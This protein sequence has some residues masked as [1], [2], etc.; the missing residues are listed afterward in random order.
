MRRGSFTGAVSAGVYSVTSDRWIFGTAGK[1]FE[2]LLK[3]TP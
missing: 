2:S 1:R 3:V